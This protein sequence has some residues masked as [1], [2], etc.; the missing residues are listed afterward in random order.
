MNTGLTAAQLRDF[1]AVLDAE[2]GKREAADA[3]LALD[4]VLASR[5]DDG[6]EQGT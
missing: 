6:A 5:G 2:V 4:A 1:I 3:A